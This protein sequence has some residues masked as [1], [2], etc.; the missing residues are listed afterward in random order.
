MHP[1]IKPNNEKEGRG[2]AA[3]QAIDELDEMVVGESKALKEVKD[4]KH[5]DD[6]KDNKVL[7]LGVC[8]PKASKQN[9]DT[10]ATN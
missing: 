5:L 6:N 1:C 8:S 4:A 2:D 3:S 7:C 9:G 10:E